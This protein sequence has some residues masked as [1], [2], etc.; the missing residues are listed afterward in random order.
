M[1]P[2]IQ[3]KHEN[4]GWRGLH[5]NPLWNPYSFNQGE[6][7]LTEEEQNVLP[8]A[9]FRFKQI[10]DEQNGKAQAWVGEPQTNVDPAMQMQNAVG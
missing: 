9:M 1:T 3:Y 5:V 4:L 10:E 7:W 6:F 2:N 8:Y